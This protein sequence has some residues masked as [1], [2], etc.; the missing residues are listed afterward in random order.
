MILR[1]YI[2]N[3]ICDYCN[4]GGLVKVLPCG[5]KICKKC[6]S[7][8]RETK[9]KNHHPARE[10]SYRKVLQAMRHFDNSYSFMTLIYTCEL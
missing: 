5:C 4:N 9:C 8:E 6:A 10:F 2:N 3:G 1:G 7:A